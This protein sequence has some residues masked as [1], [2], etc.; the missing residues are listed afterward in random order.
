MGSDSLTDE[1]RAALVTQLRRQLLYLN[2]LTE[3]MLKKNWPLND[4]VRLR[5]QASELMDTGTDNAR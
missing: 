4:P 5:R 3:K 1:Q 2:R